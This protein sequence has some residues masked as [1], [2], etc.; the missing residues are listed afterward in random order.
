ME[1]MQ[2]RNKLIKPTE[3][4]VVPFFIPSQF[5]E[6]N[7]ILPQPDGAQQAESKIKSRILKHKSSFR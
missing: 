2:K 6:L 7:A 3:K 1:L 5:P 4:V